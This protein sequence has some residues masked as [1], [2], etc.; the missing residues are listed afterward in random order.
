MKGKVEFKK[1][2]QGQRVIYIMPAQGRQYDAIRQRPATV[3]LE[4]A[5]RV[6]LAVEMRPGIVI[7]KVVRSNRVRP[8]E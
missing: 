8:V 6:R 2:R 1:F 4:Y 7:E 5:E 3:L